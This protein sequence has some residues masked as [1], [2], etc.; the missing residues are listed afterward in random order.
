[1]SPLSLA[2][3]L[4]GCGVPQAQYDAALSDANKE[5]GKAEALEKQVGDLEAEN[6]RLKSAKPAP[7]VFSRSK[8][9]SFERARLPFGNNR[10]GRIEAATPRNSIL[11]DHANA[12][13]FGPNK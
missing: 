7:G 13:D 10:Y 12:R 11:R 8:G 1:M 5:K 4:A 3:V 2:V 6:A 9:P